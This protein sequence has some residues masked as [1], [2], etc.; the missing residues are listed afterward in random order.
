MKR[1]HIFARELRGALL[2]IL[3]AAMI[4]WLFVRLSDERVAAQA[5]RALEQTTTSIRTTTTT[6]APIVID[7]NERLCSLSQTFRNDLRDIDIRLVDPEG[8]AVASSSE[9]PI[10]LGLHRDGDIPDSVRDA[11]IAAKADDATAAFA[12]T[13]DPDAETT[14]TTRAPANAQPPPRIIDR[15]KI[16]PIRS[17]LLGV[18]QRTAVNFYTAASALRLGSITAD[19]ASTADYFADF[20]RIGEPVAWDS[21][22][23]AESDFIDQWIAL[24]TRPIFGIDSTL[25]Y[26]EEECII[27]IGSGFVYREAA[28]EIEIFEPPEVVTP[29][30]P[31]VDPTLDRSIIEPADDE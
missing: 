6:A 1:S 18:P 29:I 5:Q 4:V 27:R 9:L 23:L 17:G 14:T 30:D 2:V 28:P 7:D 13:T 11:L 26:I 25:A 21:A 3:V 10:D 22:E 16:D 8:N 19:F 12:S 31:S 20:L 24:T 15:G